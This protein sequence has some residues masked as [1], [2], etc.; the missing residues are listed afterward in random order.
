MATWRK[1]GE[2]VRA[3]IV[4]VNNEQWHEK[5]YVFHDFDH[6]RYG[7]LEGRID[8]SWLEARRLKHE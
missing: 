7:E 3:P 4:M 2:L 5:L 6:P 8:E 1:A